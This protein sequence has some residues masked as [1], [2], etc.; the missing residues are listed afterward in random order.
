MRT[1]AVV[2]LGLVVLAVGCRKLQ[3]TTVELKQNNGIL[4]FDVD[5]DY[6]S[7]VA[8]G[9]DN[10]GMFGHFKV[11]ASQFPAGSATITFNVTTKGKTVPFPYTFNR[12]PIPATFQI[13]AGSSLDVDCRG[14]YCDP[15]P[16]EKGKQIKVADGKAVLVLLAPPG[17]KI[18]VDGQTTEIKFDPKADMDTPKPTLSIDLAPHVGDVPLDKMANCSMGFLDIP[19]KVTTDATKEGKLGVSVCAWR[20]SL[21]KKLEGVAK[22]P[23]TTPND[24]KGGGMPKSIALVF[25]GI[26]YFGAPGTLASLDLVAVAT[27]KDRNLGDCEYTVHTLDH[28]ATDYDIV[29]YDRRTGRTVNHRYF[30]AP[31]ADCPETLQSVSETTDYGATIDLT[32]TKITESVKDDDVLAWAK[33][34]VPAPPSSP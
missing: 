16:S 32:E 5:V 19:V 9:D 7:S 14:E 31:W 13:I 1:R 6:T 22:G 2:V 34:L 28:V 18:E 25:H 20:D 15:K 8:L 17:E 27:S 4:E 33:S 10:Q 21:T 24:T 26:N 30:A 12:D 29:V 3:P 11:P 23:L